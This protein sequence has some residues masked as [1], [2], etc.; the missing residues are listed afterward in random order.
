MP[1]RFDKI[2]LDVALKYA[3]K[4]FRK[5]IGISKHR[6]YKENNGRS[7]YVHSWSTFNRYMG[8][9]K[10]FVKR[11]FE[12]DIKRLHQ[13]DKDVVRD[14][15]L[16]KASYCSKSTVKINASA[17]EKFFE[18][19]GRDDLK[20]Y[21]RDNY[22]SFYEKARTPDYTVGFSNPGRVIE[23]LGEKK[24]I[25]KDIASLQYY[26][27]ARLGDIKKTSIDEENKRVIIEGSKGGKNRILDYSDRLDKFEIVKDSYERVKTYLEEHKWSDLR[28]DYVEAVRDVANTLGERYTGTHA[29][30]VNYA[31]E[32]YKEL[33]YKYGIEVADETLTKELGHERISMSHYY[34]Y[35]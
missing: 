21:I 26:T 25:Y 35:K 5:G 11:C 22:V 18:S 14:F 13:V 27:G 6:V 19:L 30:R 29:F 34:A 8:V 31:S 10:D 17:L 20:E 32:R 4:Q 15:L 12:N 24:P 3:S 23:K 7:P 28:R 1:K 33:S 2:A 16:D 9:A